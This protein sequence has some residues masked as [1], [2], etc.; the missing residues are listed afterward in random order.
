MNVIVKFIEVF[1]ND[2]ADDAGALSGQT[3]GDGI[4]AVTQLSGRS[5]HALPEHWADAILPFGIEY[6]ADRGL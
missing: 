5:Q 1:R 3:P 6:P 2:D 4:R